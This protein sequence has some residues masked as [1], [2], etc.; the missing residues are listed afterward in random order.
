MTSSFVALARRLADAAPP[1]L[2]REIAITGSVAAGLAD[3]HSDLELLFLV[4]GAPTPG[5]VRAWLQ[6]NAATDVL[7]GADPT[8]VW[9][10][11]RVDGVEVEPYWDELAH[12]RAEAETV[13]AG[14][15]VEHE[16]VALAHV[17]TRSAVLRTEGALP[18]LVDRLSRYPEAVRRQ[19]VLD[20]AAGLEVPSPR[21]GAAIRDDRVAVEATLL[22]L[23]YRALR[24]VFAVNR[25]W[26]PPRWKWLARHLGELEAAPPRLAERMG[27]ALVERDPVAAVAAMVALVQEA[28]ALVP[29]EIDVAAARAGVAAQL[30]RL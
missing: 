15:T 13:L 23:A 22:H 7:A 1:E 17:L 8:G 11:C 4:D 10:W 30:E 26:E 28:L 24:I 14:E 20:A 6:A 29:G 27:A 5:A 16:R 12:I 18:A 25:C 21:L 9:A 3:D 19:L 2:G